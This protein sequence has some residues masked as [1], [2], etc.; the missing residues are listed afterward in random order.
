MDDF[1]DSLQRSFRHSEQ[2]IDI[3]KR[4]LPDVLTV[5]QADADT[6]KRGIDYI[7]VLV[8]G[9][10]I[11][12]DV[13]RRELGAAKHWK[14]GVPECALELWSSIRTDGSS[15]AGWTLNTSTDVD[16]IL[17]LFDDVPSISLLVPFQIL[18]KA[19]LANL[20]R[21]RRDYPP[22]DQ[23]SK[24]DVCQWRS[25]VQFVPINEVMQAIQRAQLCS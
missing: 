16:F 14:N 15:K 25:M 5:E 22:I 3:I 2:D 23:V 18:R 4:I 24:R 19:Y 7:A 8:G 9:A 10:R 20:D 6:D 17:F 13:K 1:W 21:W 12:I 11:G